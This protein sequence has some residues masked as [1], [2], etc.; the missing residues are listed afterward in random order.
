MR[1]EDPL[2]GVVL[3]LAERLLD[4]AGVPEILTR[5][6]EHCVE[7]FPVRGAGVVI[8]G[9]D[10]RTAESLAAS[11]AQI[12]AVERRQI[13]VQEGPCLSAWESGEV[14]EEPDLAGAGLR[15]W[16]RFAPYLLEQGIRAVSSFPLVHQDRRIGAL[17][18]FRDQAEPLDGAQIAAAQT[19]AGAATIYVLQTD[20]LQSTQ[21]TIAQLQSALETRM[22]IEQAKGKLSQQ[23]GVGVEEAFRL[24]RK[25]A[26]DHNRRLHD[27]AGEIVSGALRLAS[28]D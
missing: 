27:V 11:D 22:V 4:D 10:P 13:Q 18:L 9:E 1:D 17:N 19:L 12:T 2:V 25:H 5:I 15:R 16:P 14:V 23:F 26:R 28:A 8:Y 3:E 20:R 6:C 21:Q 7:V 24:M